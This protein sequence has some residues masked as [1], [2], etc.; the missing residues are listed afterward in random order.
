MVTFLSHEQKVMQR[1]LHTG[2]AQW[3]FWYSLLMSVQS[4]SFSS[5][6]PMNSGLFSNVC[7]IVTICNDPQITGCSTSTTV[8]P[9]LSR[10]SVSIFSANALQNSSWGSAFC[11]LAQLLA[12]AAFASA[13]Y[14]KCTT[15]SSRQ[16]RVQWDHV[17]NCWCHQPSVFL[18]CGVKLVLGIWA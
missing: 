8:L 1:F 2:V 11:F 12:F 18:N 5:H 10:L 16:Q 14:K 6:A 3:V 17:I 9:S 7:S 15:L 4:S 13:A